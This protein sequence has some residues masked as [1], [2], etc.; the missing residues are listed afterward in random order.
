MDI[1]IT[2]GNLPQGLL[3]MLTGGAEIGGTYEP[4]FMIKDHPECEAIFKAAREKRTF[5]IKQRK[6]LD[7]QID[8]VKT[9][10]WKSIEDYMKAKGLWPKDQP[11][12]ADLCMHYDKGVVSHHIH[13]AE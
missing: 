2:G 1:K 9:D 4:L 3:E 7:E 13:D 12:D 11:H 5:L 8:Q 10:L 6:S